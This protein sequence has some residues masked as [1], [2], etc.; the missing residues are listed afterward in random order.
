MANSANQSYG[1]VAESYTQ[2]RPPLPEDAIEWLIPDGCQTAVDLGAGPGM[3]T[4]RL[5]ERIPNVLAVE[6]DQRFHETLQDNCPTATVLTGTAEDIPLPDTSVDAVFAN[7][8]WHW[9]D[10]EAALAES[11]RVLR[12]E[13]T[14]AV[15]WN[16]HDTDVPW[17]AELYDITGHPNPEALSRIGRFELPAE[18]P[19]TAP[20][21]F[22]LPNTRPMDRETF[23]RMMSTYSPLLALPEHERES[24]LE[25]IGKL[26][27]THPQLAGSE[28]I[29][30]PLRAMCRRTT[31]T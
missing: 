16:H 26:V 20:Q 25:Q 5:T 19:F 17:V 7:A 31:R 12:P 21:H 3:F 13:G 29:H 15:A 1:T 18:A 8:S 24:V 6:P 28:T 9:F 11:A 2:L 23:V 10:A 14:L 30:L 22:E 27:D 4:R